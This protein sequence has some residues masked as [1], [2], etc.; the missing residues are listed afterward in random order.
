MEHSRQPVGWIKRGEDTKVVPTCG[1]L[2]SK[3]LDVAGH[4]AWIAPRVR[5]Y[6]RD[7]QGPPSLTGAVREALAS[8]A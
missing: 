6:D 2:A 3:T 7:P 5:A 4:P 8:T 1:K